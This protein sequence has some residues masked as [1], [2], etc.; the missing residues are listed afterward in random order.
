MAISSFQ[1]AAA[2]YHLNFA[3]KM[4]CNEKGTATKE[5]FVVL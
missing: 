1:S 2:K 3:L 4:A 5:D